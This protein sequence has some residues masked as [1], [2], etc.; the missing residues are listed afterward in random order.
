MG[1]T[2]NP[3]LLKIFAKVDKGA[4]LQRRHQ[5]WAAAAV[6]PPRRSSRPAGGSLLRELRARRR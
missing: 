4:D 2:L 5:V 1:K 3:E 6:R